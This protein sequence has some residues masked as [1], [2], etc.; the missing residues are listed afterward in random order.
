MSLTE[1]RAY[2]NGRV[3]IDLSFLSGDMR[4]LL[5]KVAYNCT[6]STGDVTQPR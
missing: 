2:T 6:M 4:N 3:T 1:V 5:G